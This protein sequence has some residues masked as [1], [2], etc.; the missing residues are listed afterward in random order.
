MI[1]SFGPTL[2]AQVS[3]ADYIA[4]TKAARARFDTLAAESIDAVFQAVPTAATQD[5]DMTAAKLL[6]RSRHT[7]A[8][9]GGWSH[10]LLLIIRRLLRIRRTSS[11]CRLVPVFSKIL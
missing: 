8:P 10:S 9:R 7:L 6:D 1:S 5:G 2:A 4:L 11:A 3:P